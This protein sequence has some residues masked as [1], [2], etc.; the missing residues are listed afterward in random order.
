MHD[1]MTPRDLRTLA[2]YHLGTDLMAR[3]TDAEQ[4]QSQQRQALEWAANRIDELE[5]QVV[6]LQAANQQHE[7]QCG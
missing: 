1:T 2:C 7:T 6:T 4:F 3:I 5:A